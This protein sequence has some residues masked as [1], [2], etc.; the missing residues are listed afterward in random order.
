[1]ADHHGLP[2]PGPDTTDAARL[3]APGAIT[4]AFALGLYVPRMYTRIRPV[5]TLG[6]D[7]Y[8]V[9]IAIVSDLSVYPSRL[10]LPRHVAP[11][12][13]DETVTNQCCFNRSY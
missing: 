11:I 8:T 9:S 7:D 10:F 4:F 2:Y 5:R 6:W 13:S 3:M 12:R 1:M